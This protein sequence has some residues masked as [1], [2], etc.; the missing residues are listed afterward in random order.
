MEGNRGT[1]FQRGHSKK[2]NS[3]SNF[4]KFTL[5]DMARYDQTAQINYITEYTKQDKL[6]YI[7]YSSGNTQ[8]YWALGMQDELPEM[9]SALEKVDKFLAVAPCAYLNNSGE[10]VKEKR[11]NAKDIMNLIDILG[12]AFFYGD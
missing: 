11:K 2:G 7:G 10:D 9:K 3:K 8:M 12:Q 4:W 1:K 6:S 5:N